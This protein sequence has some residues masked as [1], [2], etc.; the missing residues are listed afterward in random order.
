MVTVTEALTSEDPKVVKRLRGS[1]STQIS[2]NLNILEKALSQR[3]NN[4]YDYGKI[5]PQLIRTHKA[6]LQNHFD[7]VQKLHDK[8]IELREEGSDEKEEEQLLKEDISYIQDI[9]NM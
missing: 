5:S 4:D 1:C 7:L 2:C 3:I 9:I 8:F 6:K